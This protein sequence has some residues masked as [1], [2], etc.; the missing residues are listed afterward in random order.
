MNWRAKPLVSYRVIVDLISAT[1]SKTGLKV[2]CELDSNLYSK[3]ILISDEELAAIN[4]VRAE[5][6]GEW[7]YTIQPS[8]RSDR[9]VDSWRA[10]SGR[11]WPF[12][13]I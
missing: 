3:G 7:N 4:I 8:N 12:C 11:H 1:N 2:V 9:A 10:L 13:R 5:F 6:H